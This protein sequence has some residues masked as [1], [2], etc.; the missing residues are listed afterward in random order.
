MR[1][2]RYA[3]IQP[4]AGIPA[5]FPM[6]GKRS[7]TFGTRLTR[8]PLRYSLRKRTFPVSVEE[9]VML[10]RLL[11]LTGSLLLTLSAL[12]EQLDVSA[13]LA[14]QKA[15]ASAEAL[16]AAVND[17]ANAV[18]VRAEDVGVLRSAGVPE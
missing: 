16:L 4:P 17:P 9:K 5:Y 14:R 8:R 6:P 3:D 2:R 13:I 18:A 11:I 15:G 7:V 10:R 12:A 1:R